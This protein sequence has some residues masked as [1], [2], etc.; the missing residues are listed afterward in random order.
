M[1]KT[2]SGQIKNGQIK[3]GQIKSAQIKSGQENNVYRHQESSGVKNH[4]KRLEKTENKGHQNRK[5]CPVFG[6]CGGC[7]LIDLPYEE[8]LKK[9]QDRVREL[10]SKYGKV[11]PIIGMKGSPWH[12]R[13]KV[14]WAFA[15]DRKGG[16]V[17]GSYEES[18]HR[19]VSLKGCLLENKTAD[20]IMC[21]IRDLMPSFRLTG[22]NEYTGRGFLRHVL[23]RVGRMTG[24]VMVVL[25]TATNV[26][27]G[28]NNFIHALREKHPEITTIVM[29][30]NDKY[31]SMVLGDKDTVLYGK[32][33]IEDELCGKR[34]KI[35][36]HSFYQV[37]PVQT[38]VLYQ[39]AIE[40]AGFKGDENVIDAY[41][42]V[43]TIGLIAAEHV[44]QVIGVEANRDAV[45]DA[46]V[47]AKA[48]NVKNI[49]FVCADAGQYMEE[50]AAAGERADVVLMDPP[51]TGSSEAFIRSLSVMKPAK[52]VYVSCNPETLARDLG[53]L[54]KIGYKARKIVPVDMFPGTE[55]VETIVL[56]QK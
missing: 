20:R 12:Y 43:G 48:N 5:P 55:D 16:I 14:H 47:N 42:G 21:T 40:L 38:E 7:T 24:E 29:N 26:F 6:R 27:P 37:N 1:E 4:E 34:F 9:K 32:G 56:L 11:D 50:L 52:I 2:K 49:S 22:Y 30:L 13:N 15:G 53:G 41:C 18:T 8:Q 10:L 44:G 54:T 35:S 31:T 28:K 45:R 46:I 33:Y 17:A 51:R 23:I 19:I 25:V 39:T 3:H 36:P